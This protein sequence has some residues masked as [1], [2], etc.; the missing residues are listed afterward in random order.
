VQ[1]RGS[2]QDKKRPSPALFFEDFFFIRKR[3]KPFPAW[4]AQ[5]RK[6]ERCQGF[7]R[8]LHE[9]EGLGLYSVQTGVIIHAKPE[10]GVA[11]SNA[12]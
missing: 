2:Y 1:T 7:V 6:T 9:P 11:N 4:V 8:F 10:K 5:K 3:E 12:A